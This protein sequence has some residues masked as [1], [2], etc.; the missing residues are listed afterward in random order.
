MA[1]NVASELMQGRSKCATDGGRRNLRRWRGRSSGT[2]RVRHLQ[3]IMYAEDG[4][5]VAVPLSPIRALQVAGEL[6]AGQLR[7]G[8]AERCPDRV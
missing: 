5:S 2:C 1:E 6:I 3:L 4:R 8:S 7:G